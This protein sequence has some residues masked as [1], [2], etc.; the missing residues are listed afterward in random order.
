MTSRRRIAR[1]PLPAVSCNSVDKRLL[2]A[3]GRG[4]GWTEGTPTAFRTFRWHPAPHEH[5]YDPMDE[6]LDNETL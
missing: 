4:R 2:G 5:L 1:C 3:R 6:W